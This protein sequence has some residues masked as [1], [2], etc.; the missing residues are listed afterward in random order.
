[1]AKRADYRVSFRIDPDL[2]RLWLQKA[3]QEVGIRDSLAVR[4]KQLFEH[5]YAGRISLNKDG[6]LASSTKEPLAL[7][8]EKMYTGTAHQSEVLRRV[9][10]LLQAEPPEEVLTAIDAILELGEL[11]QNRGAT[12]SLYESKINNLA[13]RTAEATA[14]LA[15]EMGGP[16]A[17]KDESLGDKGGT[18][19]AGAPDGPSEVESGTSGTRKVG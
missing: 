11:V 1:M 16:S 10:A 4:A 6:T 3:T 12:D 9:A 15:S 8:G 2:K 7:N 5:W 17:T 19:D 14:N 18:G 13:A